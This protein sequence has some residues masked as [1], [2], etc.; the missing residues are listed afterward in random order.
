MIFYH[1][2]KLLLVYSWY[3]NGEMQFVI[4]NVNNIFYLSNIGTSKKF[5]Q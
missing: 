2:R 4:S 1:T 5:I 3:F